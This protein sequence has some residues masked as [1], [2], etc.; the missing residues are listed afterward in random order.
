MYGEGWA[1]SAII[2]AGAAVGAN[3]RYWLGG[4]IASRWGTTFPWGT[5]TINVSGSF[6]LGLVAGLSLA[7]GWSRGWHLFLAIGFLGGY[8]TF[9][10]FSYESWV[11]V[12]ERNY[13]PAFANAA[14]SVVLGL[15]ACWGGLVLA[16]T[17]AGG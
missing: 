5:M 1:R 10:T 12:G 4:W 2:A 11:L 6:L 17:L 7:Q 15:V 3:A 13:L 16:R 9:S 14:G 8:T